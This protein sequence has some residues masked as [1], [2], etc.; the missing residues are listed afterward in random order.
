MARLLDWHSRPLATPLLA[1]LLAC[2]ALPAVAGA[3]SLTISP[4]QRETAQRVA[5]AGV[6]LSALRADAPTSYTVKPGDTLWAISSLFLQSPWRWPELWGMNM[7]EVHNPHRIYPGQVLVL[8]TVNGRARLRLQGASSEADSG[9]DLPTVR[10]T[11]HTRAQSLP[12]A[13]LPTL[14]NSVIEPFLTEPLIVDEATFAQ[15]PRLVATQ[16]GRVLLSR[17]DR[18]YARS[19]SGNELIDEPSQKQKAY[20]VFRNATPL[21]DPLT[22]QVLGFEAQYVGRA[23]LVRSESAQAS[24]D[25]ANAKGAEVVPATLDM[26]AAKEE[27]RVGD[28]LLPEPERVLQS[29]VPRAPDF[30]VDARVV[31]VYG[32]AVANAAQNQVVTINKGS[33][34]GMEP[35]HV[36]AILKDGE[37][38][39]DP[40][41]PQRAAM[42]LPDERNGLMM[43]FRTFGH[44]SYAL[45][46]TI[47]N[48]V[49]VGDH[50]ITPH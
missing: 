27:M 34:D 38:L 25:P 30:E 3:V 20:R 50:L 37:R 12:M 22:G 29:Y 4:Q 13:A 23:L 40:T 48:G 31:S 36:L 47:T 32:S 33:D 44:L 18:A 5:Q 14:K 42:K 35:G 43:V 24:T 1:G 28:R 41:D 17:G 8:E 45:V 15:A 39:T 10:L 6:P 11:P 49:K 9:A 19:A 16:D 7:A 26:V 2:A 21:K 46:L